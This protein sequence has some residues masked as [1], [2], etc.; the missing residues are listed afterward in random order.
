MWQLYKDKLDEAHGVDAA[1]GYEPQMA[2]NDWLN[3]RS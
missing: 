3:S 2:N 1:E